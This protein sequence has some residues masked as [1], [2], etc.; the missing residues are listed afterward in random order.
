MNKPVKTEP[1]G[2]QPTIRSTARIA[3]AY[4]TRNP[5]A[6]SDIAALIK[7]IHAGL[8]A[9]KKPRQL[10]ADA[11]SRPAI[12][13]RRSVTPKQDS[14]RRPT[15]KPSVSMGLSVKRRYSHTAFRM[16]SRGEAMTSR[17]NGLHAL[18]N[19]STYIW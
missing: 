19:R 1:Q 4:V 7:S 14:W 13:V 9:R 3:Q 16:T 12:S 2:N 11:Q 18:P 6:A 17:G 5:L 8:T 10:E 15:V